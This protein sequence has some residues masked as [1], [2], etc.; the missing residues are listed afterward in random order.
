MTQ[1]RPRP[2]AD[3]VDLVLRHASEG[4]ELAGMLAAACQHLMDDGVP[5]WRVSLS[6]RA[7]DPTTTALS[8]IWRRGSGAGADIA[9]F[10]PDHR[11]MYERSPIAHV[12][13]SGA[14]GARWRIEAGEGCDRFPLLAELRLEGGTDY[15]MRIVTFG[16]SVLPAM[17]GIAL[18]IATDQPGGF[19]EAEVARIDG[20]LRALGLASYRFA[21]EDTIAQVLAVYLGPGIARRVLAGEI[22]RGMGRRITASI[23]LAD[24]RGFTALAAREDPMQVVAWLDEHLEA[25]GAPVEAEGGEVLKFTGDGLLAVFAPEECGGSEAHACEKALV[26][27]EAALARTAALNAARRAQGLPELCLDIVLH[28]GE[29]VYGN[30]GAA[31]RLDFTVIGRAVNE[32]SRLEGLCDQL[33]RNLLMSGSFAAHCGRPVQSLGRFELRGVAAAMEVLTP[34]AR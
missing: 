26:A 28:H 25:M 1:C 14:A 12:L 7:I 9:R 23:L 18:G 20:V 27:A 17:P 5:L 4:T 33:G 16:G 24:L 10:G 15:L 22:R 19:A 3:L 8:M 31:R 2:L 29:V 34:L 11:P 30:V 6:M 32:A 13:D 21:L